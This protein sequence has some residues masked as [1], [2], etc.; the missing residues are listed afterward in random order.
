MRRVPR[1]E[2]EALTYYISA[3][4]RKGTKIFKDDEDRL[5]FINLL[6]QQKIK[7]NNIFY[8]YV[9]LSKQYS[10]LM[11]TSTNNLSKTM[12][13][14]NSN[15]ANYFNRRHKRRSRL[16]KDRYRCYIIDKKNHLAEVS[17]NFHLLPKKVK[18][19]ESPFQYVWSSLPGYLNKKKREDW[20]NYDYILK[21]F[22][23]K[24]KRVSSNYRRCINERMKKQLP[25]PFSYLK[26]SIILGSQS[27]KKEVLRKHRLNDI[28]SQK[29]NDIFAKEIIALVIQSPYWAALK[30]RRKK[31]NLTILSRNAAIYFLK[32][33]T[34]LHN[35]QLCI[36]FKGLEKSSISQ[37][38]RRFRLTKKEDKAI[39]GISSRLEKE[40]KMIIESNQK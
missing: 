13:Q 11:E 27:F 9:L 21:R 38:S 35:Q 32:K 8:G 3:Y 28:G 22:K 29:G 19:A 16:F 2:G 25:S 30:N 37:M 34:H 31:Y 14:I 12:H 17:C 26:G 33:Y 15:Y 6:R 1:I 23:G 20:I 5:Y 10:F 39:K 18:V 36:Q 40:V 24:G 7:S 4:G